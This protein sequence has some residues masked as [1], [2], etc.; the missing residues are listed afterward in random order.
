MP[1]KYVECKVFS[2]KRLIFVDP[3]LQIL[4]CLRNVCGGEVAQNSAQAQ[5]R[6]L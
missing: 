4:V 3:I 6:L 5:T 1:S 2:L